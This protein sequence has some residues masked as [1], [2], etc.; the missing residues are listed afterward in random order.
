[1]VDFNKLKNIFKKYPYI[2]C[3]YLFGS[4][5]TGKKS[6]LSDVDIAVLLNKNAPKGRKLIHNLDYLSYQIACCLKV[7]E[8]DV[9]ELNTKGPVFVHN[10]LKTGKLIYDANPSERIKFVTKIISYYCDFQPQINFM[11]KYYFDGY[12]RRL[13]SI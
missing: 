3:A 13:Q 1:M 11:N 12:R 4:Y 2:T 6:A 5:A 10:V 8:V 7:K 9:I